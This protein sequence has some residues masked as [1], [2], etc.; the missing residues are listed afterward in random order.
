MDDYEFGTWTVTTG[1]SVTLESG[2]DKATY[3][4]IGKYVYLTG[5][6]RVDSDNS[7]ADFDITNLPFTA[8]ASRGEGSSTQYMSCAHYD[9][10]VG[11]GTTGTKFVITENSTTAVLA[12]LKE[13]AGYS[14]VDAESGKWVILSG[15][16]I[17]ET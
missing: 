6:L 1:N 4:K 3:I 5:Q 16:Y 7:N 13:D 14:R 8:S 15:G 9:L 17:T 10:N 2:T 12:A 11:S